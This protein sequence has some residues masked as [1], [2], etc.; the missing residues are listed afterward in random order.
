M[1]PMRLMASIFL[2]SIHLS[3]TM[4][5]R[6][7]A[8]GTLKTHFLGFSLIQNLRRLVNVSSRSVMRSSDFLVF[9]TMSST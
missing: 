3:D 4:Q 1:G 8:L 9:T 7:F 5:P 2:A 6:S